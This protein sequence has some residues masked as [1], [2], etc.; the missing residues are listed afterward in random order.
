IIVNKYSAAFEY[1]DCNNRIKI[2]EPDD[3]NVGDT[4]LI[5]QMQGAIVDST[6]TPAFG[7]TLAYYG[8]GNYEYNI[9]KTK[10][11]NVL[12]LKYQVKRTYQ[13]DRGRVQI[14]RVP[15]Y[16]NLTVNN[17]LT[18]AP[19][20]GKTGGVLAIIVND[21][22]TLNNDIDVSGKGFRGGFTSQLTSTLCN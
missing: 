1:N 17:T 14:V 7:D 3:F 8:A 19:W 22:L 15:S 20:D 12:G 21:T 5:I 9:I 11:G 16:K 10:K 18:C 6:N 4:I 13:W 2:E